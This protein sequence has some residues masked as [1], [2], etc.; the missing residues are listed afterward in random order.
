MDAVS[1]PVN[2]SRPTAHALDVLGEKRTPL[3]LREALAGRTRFAGFQRIGVPREVLS[4]RLTRLLEHG[5]PAIRPY[6]EAGSRARE[7]YCLTPEGRD[8][9]LPPAAPGQG[10]RAHR[11]GVATADAD[12]VER[13]AGAAVSLGFRPGRAGAGRTDVE[14]VRRS[15]QP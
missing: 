10:G 8:V 9:S 6:R 4:Q 14:P 7:E 13:G 5:V 11:P 2:A 1:L 3:I 15:A 12:F